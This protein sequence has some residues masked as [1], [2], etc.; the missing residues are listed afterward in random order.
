MFAFDLY[1]GNPKISRNDTSFTIKAYVDHIVGGYSGN[2]TTTVEPVILENC[3]TQHFSM[4]KDINQTFPL[5]GAADWLCLPLNKS[6]QL[7][8]SWTLSDIYSS[9]NVQFLCNGS[10]SSL[11]DNLNI[12]FYTL[13]SIANPNNPDPEQYFLD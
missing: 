3:T 11:F 9:I 12:Y 5:W 13:S 2:R 10:C 1:A 4:F 7:Q 8:G 6:Y